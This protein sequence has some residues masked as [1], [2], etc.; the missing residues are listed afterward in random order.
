MKDLK[1]IENMDFQALEEASND[2][3]V[4]I[5]GGLEDRLESALIARGLKNRKS[6]GKSLYYFAPALMAAAA[7]IAVILSVENKPKDTF[8][9]PQEAY[10]MLEE[11]FRYI[12]EKAELGIDITDNALKTLK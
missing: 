9:D 12:Q 6:K 5:P 4:N 10:A 1:T 11:T 3:T 8:S 2:R 7:S